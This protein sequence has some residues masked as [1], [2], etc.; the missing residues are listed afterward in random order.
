M[1]LSVSGG[2][3]P[4]FGFLQQARVCTDSTCTTR[5]STA[6][7]TVNG[8]ALPYDAGSEEYQGTVAIALGASVTAAVTVDGKTYTASGTQFA[9]VPTIGAPASGATWETASDNA[10]SWTGGAP[11]AGA[12]YVVGVMDAGGSFVF[13]AGDHNPEELALATHS[14]TVPAGALAGGSDK[15]MVG[16]CSAGLVGQDSGGVS[17]SGAAS[18]SAMWLGALAPFVPVTVSGVPAAPGGVATTAGNG[19]ARVAWGAVAGATAYNLYWSASAGVTKANGTKIAGVTSPYLQ[20]GLTNGTVYHYVV[21][22]VNGDGESAESIEVTAVPSAAPFIQVMALSLSGGGVPPFGFLEQAR[23][24]TDFTCTTRLSSA[25]VTVNGATL[26]YDSGKEQFAG[27]AAIALGATVTVHVTVGAETFTATGTQF[28][29]APTVSAPTTGATWNGSAANSISW[30]GGAPTTGASYMVGVMDGSGQFAFPSDTDH[31]PDEL[32]V[33]THSVAV[34]AGSVADGAYQ[35]MVGIGTTGL[36]AQNSGGIAFSGG[37]AAPGSGL[38]L[39]AVAPLVPVTVTTPPPPPYIQALA[40]T[41][42]DAGA[43]FGFLEQVRVCS[44]STCNTPITNATVQV[45]GTTLAYDSGNQQYAGT[46]G[47]ALGAS[48]T[49]HVTVGAQTFTAAGTQFTAFP[50]VSAP[51]SG[52]TWASGSAHTIAW[53]GAAPTSGATYAVGVV[54]SNG[55]FVVPVGDR[56]PQEVAIGTTSLNVAAGALVAGD[57]QVMVGI[58]TPGIAGQTTGGIPFADAASGSGLWL[59]AIASLK[60]VTVQ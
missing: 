34:P 56:G 41:M 11:T 1:A 4:A 26:T 17:F 51:V 48:V 40:L 8:S 22:A 54:D 57:Y 58:A 42:Q 15:V 3:L 27:T 39:G 30:T 46:A 9:S 13:P 45:N 16:I 31:G 60:P 37:A 7:V 43:P 47:I 23:V 21:T 6:T 35:V 29:S 14:A 53:S 44:D 19:Q 20:T 25:T 36:V 2:G 12:A 52:A 5:I 33:G 10:I 24:C 49:V 55:H 59:G 50:T 28:T 32:A 38:W 18:G